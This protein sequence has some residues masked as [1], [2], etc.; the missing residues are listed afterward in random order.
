MTAANARLWEKIATRFTS[1]TFYFPKDDW[2]SDSKQRKK[3]F[4]SFGKPR[5]FKDQSLPLCDDCLKI[6]AR[7]LS[8]ATLSNAEYLKR[9]WRFKFSKMVRKMVQRVSQGLVE[10]REFQSSEWRFSNFSPL[11][12]LNFDNSWE[13][14]SNPP[15]GVKLS[16]EK[17]RACKCQGTGFEIRPNWLLRDFLFLQSYI[18]L[19]CAVDW[20]IVKIE[21]L[22]NLH[23]I[24]ITN[25]KK[26]AKLCGTSDH[27]NSH[28]RRCRHRLV[29]VKRNTMGRDSRLVTVPI[30]R[31]VHRIY[32]SPSGEEMGLG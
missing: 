23:K 26:P 32:K 16:Q 22:E 30:K 14:I 9:S 25:T 28:S 17:R 11:V 18:F 10:K 29:L 27:S 7:C 1:F 13:K 20:K 24:F 2:K 19:H 15:R 5:R 21:K 6:A 4:S 31:H 3:N 12:C 8:F